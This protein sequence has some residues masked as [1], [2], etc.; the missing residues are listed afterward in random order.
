M[1]SSSGGTGYQIL[2]Q[3]R[4]ALAARTVQSGQGYA[5]AIDG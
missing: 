3:L 4:A 2:V 1:T 5:D